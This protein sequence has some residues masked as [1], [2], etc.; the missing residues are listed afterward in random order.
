MPGLPLK[1]LNPKDFE[2]YGTIIDLRP[3]SIDGWDILIKVPEGGWRIAVLEYTRKT[4]KRLECHSNS[5]ETFEPMEGVSVMLCA[6]AQSPDKME[7]FLLDKPVCLNEG[8]WHEVFCLS[9]RAKVKITENFDVPCEY[10][11]FQNE[12][13]VAVL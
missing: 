7:A 5:K 12:V 6:E 4:A 2:K 3:G 11:N 9:E 1:T 8:V 10:R 13:G